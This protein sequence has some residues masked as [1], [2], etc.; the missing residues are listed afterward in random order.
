MGVADGLCDY[1]GDTLDDWYE[2]TAFLAAPSGEFPLPF[3]FA[4]PP[5]FCDERCA[6]SDLEDRGFTVRQPDAHEI[7]AREGRTRGAWPLW[8]E[9]LS[10]VRSSPCADGSCLFC[11]MPIAAPG[12]DVLGFHP[13]TKHD[14]PD[15]I[16]LAEPAQFCGA[17]CANHELA[18]RGF[19]VGSTPDAVRERRLLGWTYRSIA[20]ARRGYL[21]MRSFK[22]ALTRKGNADD[23]R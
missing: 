3:N 20:G 10:A 18:A 23:V 4:A 13:F 14:I 17:D 9:T 8:L 22:R 1:C 19:E 21:G 5:A 11:G 7:T 2:V 12:Y 15:V 16:E 6:I